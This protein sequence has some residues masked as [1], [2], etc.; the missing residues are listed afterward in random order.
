MKI[1]KN[2]SKIMFLRTLFTIAFVSAILWA[3][4]KRS[5]GVDT[6]FT[7]SDVVFEM[8]SFWLLNLIIFV[9]YYGWDDSIVWPTM[10]L[11]FLS[12]A[13]LLSATNICYKFRIFVEKRNRER[14]MKENKD[15]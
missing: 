3:G 6:D 7:I 8:T 15:E 1:Y 14:E 5:K 4:Y 2:K 9:L 11:I 10:I 13:L 12:H